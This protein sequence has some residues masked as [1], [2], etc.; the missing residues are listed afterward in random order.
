MLCRKH[1]QA[2]AARMYQVLRHLDPQGRGWFELPI[3]RPQLTRKRSEHRLFGWHLM[4]QVLALGN[5]V[6]WDIV[7]D[8]LCLRR[9]AR[10]IIQLS[11]DRLTGKPVS[12]PI[13]DIVSSQGAYN[14]T[15][16]HSWLSGRIDNSPISRAA[17]EKA[18]GNPVS[19]QQHYDRCAGIKP[20]RNITII[21]DYSKEAYQEAL[22]QY[23]G[24]AYKYKDS[25]SGKMIIVRQLPNVHEQAFEHS[26]NGRMRKINS[27][28][29]HLVKI[30]QPGK[31]EDD[32]YQKRYFA[33]KQSA[34]HAYCKDPMPVR[35]WPMNQKIM[36]AANTL[37]R[38]EAT[39]MWQQIGGMA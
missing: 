18:T 33:D 4:R 10:I 35:F 1:Q 6:L 24:A 37:P 32:I 38:L 22:S 34:E 13:A 16:Y 5:G 14:R 30:P 29:P 25:R 36:R 12:V 21:G 27:E 17:I 2:P 20:E 9:P 28:I 15:V 19:T 23:G 31:C 11:G 8:R 39:C 26:A 3:I 7:G